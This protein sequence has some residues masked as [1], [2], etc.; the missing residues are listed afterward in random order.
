MS[1]PAGP[2]PELVVLLRQE[3]PVVTV[4][5]EPYERVRIQVVEIAG[6]QPLRAELRREQ[7]EIDLPPTARPGSAER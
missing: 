7:V 6:E 5:A 2:P 1:A 4:Q 3:V